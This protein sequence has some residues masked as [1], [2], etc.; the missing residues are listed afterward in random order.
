MTRDHVLAEIRR[1]ALSNGGVPLGYLG[2]AAATGI[3]RHQWLGKF[4]PRWSDAVSEAGFTPNPFDAAV[5]EEQLLE[6]LAA[7]TKELGRYP[8]HADFML[9][10]HE[11]D[12]FPSTTTFRRLGLKAE[13]I[14][15]LQVFCIARGY[16]DVLQI[17][18][19]LLANTAPLAKAAEAPNLHTA[20]AGYVY[21]V[22]HGTRR[23]FK[24]GR[25]NNLLR[26]EGEIGVE[27]PLKVH[28]MHVIETDDPAGVEAYWHRRFSKKRLNGEWFSLT[29]EDVR[30]FKR[31]TKI[32]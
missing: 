8:I 16:G 19:P 17:I 21:L 20:V 25:T 10:S 23:E 12:N 32:F 29:T 26:R 24:I 11:L 28:P 15:K 7:L 6:H 3:T 14:S 22:R 30:A 18:E 5:P 31:W 2:F 4:W 9:K 1:T 13:A 27:L